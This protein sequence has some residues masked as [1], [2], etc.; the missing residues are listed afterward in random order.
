[1][2]LGLEFQKTNLRIRISQYPQ[3]LGLKFEKTYI[4]I[5]TNIFEILC[6]YVRVCQFSD[7]FEFF[8]PNVPNN[9]LRF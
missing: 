2:D 4:E 9:G 1:M 3:D 7:S 5:K 6:L 8:G